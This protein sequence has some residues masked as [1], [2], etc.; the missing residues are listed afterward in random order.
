LGERVDNG[1]KF[2]YLNFSGRD[3]GMGRVTVY[4]VL[5]S[6]EVNPAK[7]CVLI[8]RDSLEDIDEELLAYFVKCGYSAFCVDYSGDRDSVERYTQYPGNVKYA[9]AV[10]AGRHKDYADISADRTCWYEWVAVGIY[11]R[12]FLSERFNTE[13]IGLVGIRDGGEIA[14]KLAY[15]AKFS[16]AAVIGACGW[17]AYKGIEKFSGKEPEFDE[18]RYRFIAG[19][20]S[21]SYA[22]YVRCPMLI[23]CTTN[24]PSFDYDR[25]YDTFSRIN[26]EFT[27]MSSIVYSISCG[28]RIDARCTN[29]M[30]MF[31]DGYVKGRH[32][33]MPKPVEVNVFADE[34]G[35]LVARVLCDSLGIIEKCGVYFAEDCYDFATRDW[36]AAKLKKSINPVESEFY[37]N[38]YEKTSAIFVLCYAVYSNGFTVWSKLKIKKI[39]GN[40][41]NG[42][43]KSN[44]IYTSKFGTE[45]FS[46]ADCSD[47]DVGGILLTDNDV[48]PRI[49]TIEGLKGIYSKCGLMT[50]RIKSLQYSPEKDSILK[51]DVCSEENIT[52]DV[53]LRNT[54]DG[55][56]YSVKL[57]VLGGVW[58]SQSLKA[59]VFK[60]QNGVSLNSFIDCEALS[61]TGSGKFA[62]NNLIWL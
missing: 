16:C 55:C 3:T 42:S 21:Q 59:K 37:L 19:I 33:F 6:K 23:L 9:N 7:E 48:L 36:T 17:R 12:K 44:I 10:S 34:D 60:N 18:E 32:V 61:V 56:I 58:Q 4:G 22:P 11:A 30:F 29:D 41:R 49:V 14:W 20:D 26:P 38:L 57:Y 1:I 35:N 51:L 28:S 8:L 45:C 2:E 39:S 62:L 40:F 31:L 54:V 46:I 13:N 25:A 43:A 52:L 5:A 24:D 50:N 47:Y 53:S 27:R 15:V